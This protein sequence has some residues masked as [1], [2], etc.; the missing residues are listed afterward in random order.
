MEGVSPIVG[1]VN[2]LRGWALVQEGDFDEAQRAFEE[3]LRIAKL[4]DPNYGDNRSIDYD[5]VLALD[6][7]VRVRSRQ[8]EAPVELAEL[9]RERDGIVSRLGIRALPEFPFPTDRT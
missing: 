3:S 9:V 1:A 4:H 6:G 7:L 8:E 2:R 5:V